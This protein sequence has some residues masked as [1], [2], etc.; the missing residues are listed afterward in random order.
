MNK[1]DKTTLVDARVVAF[2]T[3]VRLPSPPP[4][5]EALNE[6]L[7]ETVSITLPHWQRYASFIE[8]QTYASSLDGVQIF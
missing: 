8:G 2:L 1:I 3:G 4:K 7:C 5:Y 6:V